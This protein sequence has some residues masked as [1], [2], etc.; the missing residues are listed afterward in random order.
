MCAYI[1]NM[2]WQKRWKV[3]YITQDATDRCSTR[4]ELRDGIFDVNR[5]STET[6][7]WRQQRLY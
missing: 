5:S 3:V 6:L 1:V 2:T 4:W 7:R